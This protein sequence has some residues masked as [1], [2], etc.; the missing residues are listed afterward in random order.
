M[1]QESI[2]CKLVRCDRR[3]DAFEAEVRDL[4]I[5]IAVRV[6][7][8]QRDHLDARGDLRDHALRVGDRRVRRGAG[9]NVE[10]RGQRA[11]RGPRA[12]ERDLQLGL[13]LFGRGLGAEPQLGMTVTAGAEFRLR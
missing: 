5:E 2:E 1:P 11:G 13:G 6:V 12:L 8:R 3:Y 9:M 10:I 4:L 7:V